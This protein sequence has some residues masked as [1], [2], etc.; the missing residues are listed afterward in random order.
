MGGNPADV[1]RADVRRGAQL[2][3]A[4]AS[5]IVRGDGLWASISDSL[6]DSDVLELQTQ[7]LTAVAHFSSRS[8]IVDVAALHVIDSFM[9]RALSI[10]ARSNAMLGATTYVVGM[11]PEV[12]DAMSR[13]GLRLD[14]ATSAVDAD[15]VLAGRAE[16]VR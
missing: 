15:D 6:T 11:R 7:I 2:I 4:P 5:S 16:G 13:L 12:A 10:V 8:V 1:R 9:A 3:S 14:A